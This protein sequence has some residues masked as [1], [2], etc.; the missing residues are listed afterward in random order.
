MREHAGESGNG[1]ESITTQDRG[2][3]STLEALYSV[4]VP[5]GH[6]GRTAVQQTNLLYNIIL[7]KCHICLLSL[8][9]SAVRHSSTRTGIL[10]YTP[11][12]SSFLLSIVVLIFETSRY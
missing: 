6:V 5:T 12:G 7:F 11:W 2:A 10:H 4:F 9:I 1:L 3:K 8:R